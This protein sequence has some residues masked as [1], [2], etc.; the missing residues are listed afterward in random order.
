MFPHNDERKI[1]TNTNK[2]KNIFL[3]DLEEI[4]AVKKTQYIKIQ[5]YRYIKKIRHVH[6]EH[7]KTS[8]V[9]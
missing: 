7:N 3:I 6:S 2:P 1:K 5:G 4:Q 8:Q 9:N